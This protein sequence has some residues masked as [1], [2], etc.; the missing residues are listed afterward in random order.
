MNHSLNKSDYDVS[1]LFVKNY[2]LHKFK[3]MRKSDADKL[4]FRF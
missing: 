4:D 2:S 3:L 1:I